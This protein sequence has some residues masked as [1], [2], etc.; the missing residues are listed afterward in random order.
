MREKQERVQMSKALATEIGLIHSNISNLEDNLREFQLY[1]TFIDRVT[2][3]VGIYCVLVK[4]V[5]WF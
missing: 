3:K 4:G 5:I 2:P 1:K